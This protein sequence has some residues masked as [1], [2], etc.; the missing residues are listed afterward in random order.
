MTDLIIITLAAA[1]PILFWPWLKMYR[2]ARRYEQ[3][4]KCE[5]VRSAEFNSRWM[6]ADKEAHQ[7][8]RAACAA[9]REDNN[10]PEFI[11]RKL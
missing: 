4:Y 7:I 2:K 3:K 10:W 9:L 1:S 5:R 8:R 6:E 11:E